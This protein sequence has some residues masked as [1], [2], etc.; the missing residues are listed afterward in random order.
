[1]ELL[2][3]DRVDLDVVALEGADVELGH[4]AAVLGVAGHGLVDHVLMLLTV[5]G[6]DVVM[7]LHDEVVRN[8][9]R[10][11]QGRWWW[12]R[13]DSSGEPGDGSSRCD[14][15]FHLEFG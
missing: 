15:A 8:G 13:E 14:E 9:S 3:G 4:D 6:A 7:V 2:D 10:V 12:S 5:G 11:V 1:M